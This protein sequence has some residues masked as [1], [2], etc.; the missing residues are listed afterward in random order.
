[1]CVSFLR[2]HLAL[3]AW[4]CI[5]RSREHITIQLA[6]ISL[7]SML[8]PVGL[9]P[10]FT[11]NKEAS[12]HTLYQTDRRANSILVHMTHR[13]IWTYGFKY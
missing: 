6:S 13:V 3:R 9:C 5:V 2:S 12:W 8:C 1:M 11:H 7:R 4:F 10:L